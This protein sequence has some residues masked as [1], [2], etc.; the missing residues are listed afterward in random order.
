MT[1]ASSC[2]AGERCA[3]R[4]QGCRGSMVLLHPGRFDRN[5]FLSLESN[6]TPLFELKIQDT[7]QPGNP[8]IS[9]QSRT[10]N[11]WVDD[12]YISIR[13]TTRGSTQRSEMYLL[14]MQGE[15]FSVFPMSADL[16]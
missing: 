16:E 5:A 3:I 11:G 4:L 6:V 9:T 12:I 15:V 10:S 1:S 8:I 7:S 13:T 14:F 2:L